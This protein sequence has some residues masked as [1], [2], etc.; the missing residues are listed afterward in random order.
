[1]KK[2]HEKFIK[3]NSDFVDGS[4]GDSED[5]NKKDCGIEEEDH[6]HHNSHIKK[7]LVV[8]AGIISILLM[9]SYIFVSYPISGIIQGQLASIPLEKN[10]LDVGDFSII[11]E[12]GTAKELESFYLEEQ[13]VEFSVCLNGYKEGDYH[14]TSLYKPKMFQQS[15]NHVSFE[16][17]SANSIILLHTHPYKSCIASDTDINTLKKSRKLNKDVLMVV[18]CEPERF[19]VY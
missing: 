6:L 13:K 19:S 16:P 12:G 15:F 2:E 10:K 5:N 17:C 14:I 8:I 4:V 3:D 18:M 11:F 1:M 7:I 9:I